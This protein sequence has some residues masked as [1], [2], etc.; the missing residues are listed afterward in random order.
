MGR[1]SG[2]QNGQ[3]AW[4]EAHNQSEGK[5]KKVLGNISGPKS[6]T[7]LHSPKAFILGSS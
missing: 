2:S 5:V 7:R 3:E 1:L 6:E 4:L